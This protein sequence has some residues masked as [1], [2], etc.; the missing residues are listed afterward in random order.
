MSGRWWKRRLLGL[1]MLFAL[2]LPILAGCAPK[3]QPSGDQPSTGTQQDSQS[4]GQSP[5]PASGEKLLRIGFANVPMVDPAVGSDEASSAGLANIYDTLVFPNDDGSVR[6]HV[7]KDWEVSDDGLTYTFNLE[8]GIKFHNGDE[9][10][11]A[12]VLYSLERIMTIGEGYGY[13]F[14]NSVESAKALDTYRIEIK[15]KQPFGPFLSSLVRLYI[16]NKKQVEANTQAQGSYGDKGDYGKSWLLT[17][18]AGSGPY[19]VKEL[20]EGDYLLLERFAG[21]FQPTDPNNPDQIKMLNKLEPATTRTMLAN[22]ELEVTDQWQ[23]AESYDAYAQMP[24][25]EVASLVASTTLYLMTHVR[26]P[27]TDDVHFRRALSYLINYDTIANVIQPGSL[28]S[29]GPVARSLP[30]HNSS[31][32]QYTYDLAKAE[33]HLKQSKYYGQLDQ[34]PLDVA[35]IAETPD[36]EKLALMIQADAAKL[37]IK[38]NVVKVPWLSFIDQAAKEETAPGSGLVAVA[39]HYAEAG[40]ILESRFHSRSTGT[41]EQT[42]WVRDPELDQMIDDAIGTLDFNARMEKYEAIQAKVTDLAIGVPLVD[43]T[44]KH[45]YQA[46]YVSWRQA[47]DAKAGRPVNPVLGYAYYGLDFKVYPEKK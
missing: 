12:D 40:S 34:Y 5:A 17:H 31:L 16:L 2:V 1:L 43:S 39:A 47:E 29:Q 24:G 3:N 18:D 26:K 15:L 23:P 8:Q 9:L 42:D 36:R 25:V 38:V 41:W 4:T 27:P 35:W 46:T 22:K 32:Q 19:M 21:Y 7:A 11:A 33:E 10:T 13:L 28:P 20:R 45:G 14:S 6:P 44:E 30:G 37:G